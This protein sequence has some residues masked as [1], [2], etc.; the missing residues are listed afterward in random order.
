VIVTFLITVIVEGVVVTG[1]SIWQNKPVW[2]LLCT[3]FLG[4]L[5]TQ[6]MLWIV[7]SFAFG[8]YLIAL[9]IAEIFI[10]GIES[11]LLFLI[12]TNRLSFLEAAR[13]SLAMNLAS[14]V[15]GWFL[16]V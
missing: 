14:L 3:S 7:L 15:L 16:P 10:W 2:S 4:N 8:H 12:P 1:Y 6:S 11:F 9:L 13:L 5:V